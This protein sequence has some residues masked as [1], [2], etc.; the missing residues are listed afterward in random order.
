MYMFVCVCGNI[1]FIAELFHTVL[2]RT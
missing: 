2:A 1:P